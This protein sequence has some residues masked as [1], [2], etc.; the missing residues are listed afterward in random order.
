MT[1]LRRADYDVLTFD[2]YGTLVDWGSGIVGYLQPLL[3]EHDAHVI[4][5]FLLE[6]F[7]ETEPQVQAEGARYADVLREVLRRLG[8]RL[9]FAP[10]AEALNGFAASVP[11][12]P[13][14]DD[15]EDALQRLARHFDLVVVSNIDNA[16]FAG[17]AN[18]LGVDFKHVVTA[19]NVG[20]YKPD[21]RMFDAALAAIGDARPLH[22]A[23][24]LFHDIA[25]ANALGIDSVW[26][27]RDRNAAR[28]ADAAPTWSFDTLADF[29]D[30]VGAE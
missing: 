22:V 23:Q 1:T 25:P 26:I 11:D 6:F 28:T 15:T 10:S 3:L 4:D 19:Q 21:Q 20:A 5:D 7:A 30:A 12:W 14:F 27:K 2:C 18:R 8:K 24:S 9:G 17:T 16:I 29:A 13:L